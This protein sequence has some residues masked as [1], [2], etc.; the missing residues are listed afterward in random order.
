MNDTRLR[1]HR[2]SPI[3]ERTYQDAHTRTTRSDRRNLLWKLDNAIRYVLPYPRKILNY[4]KLRFVLL[5][6]KTDHR[7]Y[8]V[9][10]GV[11]A[12]GRCNLRCP[13][14]PRSEGN[15]R[16]EGDMEWNSYTNLIDRFAPYLFQVRLHS[17]G[18]PML[19]PNLPQMAAYA[20]AKG[21][22]TNFHTNGHFLTE[23]SIIALLTSG[24]DEIN[25]ALDG[26]SQETYTRYR[27]GG[28][29]E[30]VR[31]GVLALCDERRRLN[32]TR[33]RI[34]LQFLV[35]AHNE[36]EIP[37]LTE[38]AKSTGVDRVFLKSVNIATGTEAGNTGY[39]P[40]DKTYRR[41]REGV[42]GL[43]LS[44]KRRCTRVFME[45]IVNWDG[46]VSIC[47]G[48]YGTQRRVTGNFFRDGVETVLFGPEYAAARA[49]SLRMEYDNCS[50]CIDA[51]SPV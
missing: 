19:N 38:F 24:I 3:I 44:R 29:F 18:E 13:L 37:A 2:P 43:E 36:H 33:P 28:S 48:D 41:Y 49:K 27:I 12:S 5:A 20:H 34:N 21:I 9:K 17:L 16:T 23:R 26:M 15:T 42:D 22:Y 47:S 11:E 32:L 10:L 8:P 39:L 4:L 50:L 6:M 1:E 40:R 7:C 46:S 45:S 35:M 25:I 31:N 14:C 30:R 51:H